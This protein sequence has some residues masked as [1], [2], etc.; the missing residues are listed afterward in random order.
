MI[1]QKQVDS[2]FKSLSLQNQIKLEERTGLTRL[3]LISVYTTFVAMFALQ[4]V[5]STEKD[6]G[7]PEQKRNLEFDSLKRLSKNLQF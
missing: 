7:P 4:Q 3:E 2:N 6:L 5:E 1:T